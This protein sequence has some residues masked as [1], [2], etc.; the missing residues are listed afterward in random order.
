MTFA[1]GAADSTGRGS[2]TGTASQSGQKTKSLVIFVPGVVSG[3]PIYE[4]LVSGVKK[5]VDEKGGANLKVVEGGFNQAEWESKM[6]S[7]AASGAYDL[8]ISSNPAMPAICKAVAD[9]FPKQQ[10][11]LFDGQ[12]AGNTQIYTLRYNQREQAFLAGYLAALVAKQSG[13]AKKLGLV[14]GQEYPAMNEIILPGFLQGARMVDSG[15]S[16]DF[17][18]V[19][20]WYDAAKGSDLAASMIREGATVILPIAGGANQGV[21]QAAADGNAKVVWFDVNGYSIKPGVVVGSA[22]LKQDRAAYEKTKLYLEGTLP[23]G[24]AELVGVAD[25]YVDFIDDDPAYIAAV[26]EAVRKQQ[27]EMVAQFRSGK[28]S[29]LENGK[30]IRK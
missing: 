20:N 6:T 29:L 9:K 30:E 14:A 3:S 23:F 19:G 18:V 21:V 11:L 8:I 2:T 5:A 12:L 4:M 13:S 15:F 17:R 28:F 22:I 1:G 26:S 24:K 7:L 16:V 25:G 27:A 10:F